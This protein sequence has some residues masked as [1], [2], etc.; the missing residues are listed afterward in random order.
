MQAQNKLKIID[1]ITLNKFVSAVLQDSDLVPSSS[2]IF[3][4]V[5]SFEVEAAMLVR[6]PDMLLISPRDLRSNVQHEL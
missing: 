2:D 3:S 4:K 1:F 6:G 5:S